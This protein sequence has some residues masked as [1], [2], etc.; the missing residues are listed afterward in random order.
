MGAFNIL[1]YKESDKVIDIF[2]L[3]EQPPMVRINIKGEMRR[4]NL[5]YSVRYLEELVEILTDNKD[6]LE[7]KTFN[8]DFKR[9]YER[10]DYGIYTSFEF[11]NYNP[12]MAEFEIDV[13]V[14]EEL[15]NNLKDFH[16]FIDCYTKGAIRTNI[17]FDEYSSLFGNNH[18]SFD[19]PAS[20]LD[21]DDSIYSYTTL[22]TDRFQ[23]YSIGSFRPHDADG[24]VLSY[25]ERFRPTDMSGMFTNMNFDLDYESIWANMNFDLDY[26]SMWTSVED[27][28]ESRRLH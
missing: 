6:D 2:D 12:V 14:P 5:G 16:D 9:A 26:E 18:R 3:I 21:E 7:I 20:L 23:D 25:T 22:D 11:N 13:N 1:K 27:S 19:L 28:I 24:D 15:Y 8:C 17:I 10:H 4:N